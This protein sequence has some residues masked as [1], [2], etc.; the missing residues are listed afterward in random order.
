MAMKNSI[1]LIT[2]VLLVSTSGLAQK[3]VT[4][5]G[6]IDFEASVPSFEEVKAKNSTVSAILNTETGELASLA[7]I[8]GF[9]F[10]VALMEEHFNE[11]YMES[12]Q[13]PKAIVK[14]KIEGL[15]GEE[16]SEETTTYNFKGSITIHGVEQPLETQ[17]ELTKKEGTI[18]MTTSFNLKPEDFEIEIPSI[19]SNKIAGEVTVSAMYTLSQR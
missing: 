15:S 13:F 11:N 14:G 4:K 18:Q 17:V 1:Y 12:S 8:Q 5:N 10:K 3:Y 2:L 6:V 16:L 7:L 19:V 9:R